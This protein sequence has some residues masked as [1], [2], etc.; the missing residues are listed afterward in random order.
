MIKEKTKITF[1]HIETVG[2]GY[3]KVS[4]Y[5]LIGFGFDMEK[6]FTSF[7]Y[8]DI[9]SHHEFSPARIS[10]H[11]LV[12]F[13]QCRLNARMASV[14]WPTRNGNHRRGVAREMDNRQF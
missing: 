11:R 14:S 2:H 13:C 6:D 4:L 5:D 1:T 8:I 12:I 7:S 9:G 3:L 10:F